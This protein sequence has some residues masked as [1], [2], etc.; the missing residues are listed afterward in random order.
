M[1]VEFWVE[2]TLP[3]GQGL[4]R[5]PFLTFPFTVMQTGSNSSRPWAYG[6]LVFFLTSAILGNKLNEGFAFASKYYLVTSLRTALM[7]RLIQPV[8]ITTNNVEETGSLRTISGWEGS[9]KTCQA[10]LSSGS[11]K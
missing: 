4:Q 9:G 5:L 1:L 3:S 7:E 2:S 11:S 10:Q 6:V 8:H